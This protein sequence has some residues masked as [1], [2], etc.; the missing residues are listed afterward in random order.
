MS[1]QNIEISFPILVPLCL[2]FITLKL[3]HVI[4]WSWWLVLSPLILPL[5]IWLFGLLV[6]LSYLVIKHLKI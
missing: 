2:I 6:Y 3:C 5:G 1:K 4:T